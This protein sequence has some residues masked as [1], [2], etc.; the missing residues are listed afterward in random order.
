MAMPIW[1]DRASGQV[2]QPII[3]AGVFNAAIS[4]PAIDGGATVST[5]PGADNS[6]VINAFLS[7]AA[8]KGGGTVEVPAGTYSSNVLFMQNNVNLQL[9]PGTT[10]Q[11]LVPAN[12][13]VEGFGIGNFEISG[14][15]VLNDNASTAAANS[16]MVALEGDADFAI[17]NV[18]IENAALVHF[19]AQF[20]E[21]VTVNNVT[22]ADPLGTKTNGDGIDYSG[23][24]FLF[25][26]CNISDGDDDIVA[27]PG[28][29]FSSNI[30]ITNCTIG[31]GHG[32]S[33]GGQTNAGLVNMTVTNCTFNGTTY[34][35]RLKAGRTNGGLVQNLS[36]SNITMTNV[37]HPLYITGYYDAG[38]DQQPIDADPNDV[39]TFTAGET[40]VWNNISFNNVTSINPKGTGPIVYGLGESPVTALSFNNVNFSSPTA[41]VINFAGYNTA[42]GPFNS[43]APP[44]PNYEVLFNNSTINGIQL[45]QSSLLNSNVFKQA[46]MGQVDSVIVIVPEPAS[47]TLMAAALALVA[48]RR[49]T[50]RGRDQREKRTGEEAM[51]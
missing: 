24:N 38:S 27:K 1:A 5:T 42:N 50:R 40:P 4:N 7:Y 46:P 29:F 12:P 13:I 22:I 9:D 33:I 37:N 35:I 49:R 18:T 14:G 47:A 45:T 16:A 51:L 6:G 36:F 30:T 44:D 26:N 23:S 32:I 21:N 41:M 11:N 39:Q 3:P 19:V 8:F 15:G 2:V 28:S 43:L 25:E 48:Q 20:D 17:N 31:A 10:I 34:G